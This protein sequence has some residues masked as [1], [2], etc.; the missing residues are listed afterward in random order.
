MYSKLK[1]TLCTNVVCFGFGLE[2][3]QIDSVFKQI[4]VMSQKLEKALIKYIKESIDSNTANKVKQFMDVEALVFD[5]LKADINSQK[6]NS[7]FYDKFGMRNKDHVYNVLKTYFNSNNGN[8]NNDNN[9]TMINDEKKDNNEEI[10][11]NEGLNN[12]RY[13]PSV[14]M[15]NN[16]NNKSNILDLKDNNRYTINP[17]DFLMINISDTLKNSNEY[18]LFRSVYIQKL[19]ICVNKNNDLTDVL[20]YG[21]HNGNKKILHM[22]NDMYSRW[23]WCNID[24]VDKKD[25]SK[26]F[27]NHE[28]FR[29]KQYSRHK[30]P[31]SIKLSLILVSHLLKHFA[32]LF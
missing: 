5:D 16:C 29:G 3:C 13:K 26:F 24:S 10:S 31:S 1:C 30:L 20:F 32:Y 8:S 27:I 2:T 25:E 21:F 18:K 14:N 6:H 9:H 15:S 19:G 28:Y 12:T 23:K 7:L 22:W 4:H 11:D 17:N